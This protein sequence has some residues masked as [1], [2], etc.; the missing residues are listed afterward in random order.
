VRVYLPSTLSGLRQLVADGAV[1]GSPLTAF[2]VTGTL[3]ITPSTTV[4]GG[5]V[6]VVADSGVQAARLPAVGCLLLVHVLADARGLSPRLRESWWRCTG[7][8]GRGWATR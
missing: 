5:E 2:A 4:V 1:Y 8:P 6:T 7:R 3:T